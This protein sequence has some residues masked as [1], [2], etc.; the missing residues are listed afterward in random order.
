VLNKIKRYKGK[1][2]TATTLILGD[3]NLKYIDWQSET[4]RKPD[5]IIQKVMPSERFASEMHRR[6]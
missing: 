4:I 6:S 1:H 5:T 3:F 2:E